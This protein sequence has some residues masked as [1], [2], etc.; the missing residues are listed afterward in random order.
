M[1]DQERAAIEAAVRE[2]AEAIVDKHAPHL[3][4]PGRLART[5]T[6]HLTPAIDAMLG[7]RD[8][9]MEVL[10]KLVHLYANQGERP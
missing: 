7:E 4:F 1:T 9:Q 10:G 2:A 3:S 5:I 8:K 6:E